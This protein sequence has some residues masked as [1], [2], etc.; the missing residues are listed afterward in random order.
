MQNKKIISKK[1]EKLKI[2]GTGEIKN[3]INLSA[4]FVSKQAKDKIEKIGGKLT[5]IK[6]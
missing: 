3:K 5:L 1:Y 6:N 4:N 2:L